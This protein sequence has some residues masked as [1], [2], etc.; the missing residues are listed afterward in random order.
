MFGVY[1]CA[2]SAGDV[3]NYGVRSGVRQ[4]KTYLQVTLFNKSLMPL[5]IEAGSTLGITLRS[6]IVV[7]RSNKKCV[8]LLQPLFW[9]QRQQ[10]LSLRARLVRATSAIRGSMARLCAGAA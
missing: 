7:P 9:S 6:P 2:V 1:G 3:R 10:Q 4:Q 5:C 8:Q